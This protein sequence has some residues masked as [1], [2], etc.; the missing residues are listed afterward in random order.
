MRVRTPDRKVCACFCF[1]NWLRLLDW[2]PPGTL[3]VFS[4][5]HGTLA[6]LLRL[7][8]SSLLLPFC[9]CCCYCCCHHQVFKVQETAAEQELSAFMLYSSI[10]RWGC[11]GRGAGGCGAVNGS[12]GCMSQT[13]ACRWT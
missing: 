6:L 1:W 4:T 7:L 12:A 9:C 13:C 5:H 2:H 10:C 8:L 3:R 11:G